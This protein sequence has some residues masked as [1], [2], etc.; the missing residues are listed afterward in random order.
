MGGCRELCHSFGYPD[1]AD[2]R[3]CDRAE[4]IKLLFF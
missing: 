4:S 1:S 3:A 2:I